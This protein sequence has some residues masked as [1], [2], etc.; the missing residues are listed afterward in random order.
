MY[1]AERVQWWLK[2]AGSPEYQAAYRRIASYVPNDARVVLDVACGPGYLLKLLYDANPDRLLIGM[3]ASETMLA[4]AQ[5][6]FALDGPPKIITPGNLDATGTGVVLVKDNL[7]DAELP[8][9]LAD[10]TTFTFPETGIEHESNEIDR[11]LMVR[12]RIIAG[13]VHSDDLAD[14]K[15]TLRGNYHLTK[16]TKKNGTFLS[17]NYDI[18]QGQASIEGSS[19][20]YSK[21]F[22]LLFDSIEFVDD[23]R[24]YSDVDESVKLN[25]PKNSRRGYF[26]VKRVRA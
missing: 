2:R 16:L 7:M 24:I 10:F 19:K 23:R 14:M 20:L 8:A 13:H 26:I 12:H 9:E 4:E 5:N 22:G 25:M 17:T 18:E 11:R 3:D 1:T 21:M 6:R 15:A